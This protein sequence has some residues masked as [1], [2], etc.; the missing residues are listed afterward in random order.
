MHTRWRARREPR[1]HLPWPVDEG[2][3][4]AT[5][6]GDPRP[7]TNDIE[8]AHWAVAPT[9]I[10]PLFETALRHAAGRSVVEH[11]QAVGAL[12]ARFAAVAEANPHAWSRVAYSAE[13][14]SEAAPD[15]RMVVFPYTKR[16]CANI[17]VDQGAALILCSYEAARNAQI[18]DDRLVF[19]HAGADAH[20]RWFV[21]ERAALAEAPA[22]GVATR[23]ALDAAG[24]GL[25]D[26]ARFDLYSCFPA[27]VEM[28]MRALG[29]QGA[30]AGDE[31]PLTVT[32]GL[33]FAGG[34]VNNYP[35]HGIARMVDALR[36]DP[37]SFGLTTALGWYATKHSVG[38]WSTRPPDA[39]VRVDPEETQA[40]ADALPSRRAAGMV[41][42][43][44]TVEGTSVVME[45]D[46][47]PSV[48]IVAGLLPDGSRALA[49]SRDADVMTEMTREPW[50]G[51]TVAVT[52]DGSTNQLR[53]R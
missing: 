16:M 28:A 38:V 22:I 17:D 5:V 4:C 24:I 14:I 8:Q 39:F 7:G 53:L 47:T 25:D 27:A 10:Y 43:E 12:W 40:E 51:R 42:G 23:A 26:V 1:V 31:R 33:G 20:D 29:L 3:P 49:N 9:H 15:N 11:Q 13:E 45:R 32:G 37:G 35:T 21:T 18:P 44:M 6:I 36:A 2:A 30:E 48:A 50:E 52:N 46:G 34:P 41:D 19:L